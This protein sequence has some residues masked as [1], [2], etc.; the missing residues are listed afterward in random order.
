M[1]CLPS[2]PL[3]HRAL[4][5]LTGG[6][7]GAG[8]GPLHVEGGEQERAEEAHA[9]DAQG[10]LEAPRGTAVP[11]IGQLRPSERRAAVAHARAIQC[12][13]FVR[14]INGAL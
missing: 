9:G 13:V 14:Y 1:R 4:L 3:A 12:K 11:V 6:R 2:A 5:S 7:Q 8:L 10:D